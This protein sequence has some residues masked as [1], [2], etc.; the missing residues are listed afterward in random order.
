MTDTATPTKTKAE[1]KVQYGL[2]EEV[3]ELPD[4]AQKDSPIQQLLA[5]IKADTEKHGKWIG[6]ARYENK[7]AATAAANVER[8]RRGQDGTISGWEF[9]TR[10][11]DEGKAALLFVRYDPSKVSGTAEERHARHQAW[12]ED[13]KAKAEAKRAEQEKAEAKTKRET[14]TKTSA[15]AS[16]KR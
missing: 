5:Q 13:R 7:T 9:A 11:V 15:A 8:R 2:L 16:S 6:I 14:D 12:L 1:R 3:E 4:R 10:S